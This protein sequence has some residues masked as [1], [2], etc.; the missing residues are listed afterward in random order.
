MNCPRCKTKDVRISRRNNEHFLSFLWVTMRCHRC[1]HLFTA[2]A[3]ESA[4]SRMTRRQIAARRREPGEGRIRDEG[5][6]KSKHATGTRNR[7]P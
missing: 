7:V 6:K 1:C 2:G 4:R 3:G 5:S